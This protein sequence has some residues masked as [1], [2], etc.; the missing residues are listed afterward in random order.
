MGIERS[1]IV[2]IEIVLHDA[3]LLRLWI[4]A[5]HF[6]H[7]ECVLQLGALAMNLRQTLSRQRLNGSEQG[8]G[9]EFLIGI[10][11]FTDLPTLQGQRFNQLAN[12]KTRSLIIAKYRKTPVIGQSIQPQD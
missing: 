4:S 7:K 9:T 12:Q 5:C 6:E 3:N 8:A 2:G 1:G 10:M 11:L